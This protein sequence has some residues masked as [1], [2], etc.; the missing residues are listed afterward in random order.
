MGPQNG[1]RYS[2]VSSGLNVLRFKD[3]SFFWKKKYIGRKLELE[4]LVKLT[5]DGATL[6]S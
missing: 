4:M 6:F 3:C 5:P 2:E 1:G